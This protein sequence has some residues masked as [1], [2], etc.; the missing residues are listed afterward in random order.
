[1]KK[2]CVV[3]LTISILFCSIALFPFNISAAPDDGIININLYLSGNPNE[4]LL[5]RSINKSALTNWNGEDDYYLF[6]KVINYTYPTYVQTHITP[7]LC[8]PN[9]NSELW[10]IATYSQMYILSSAEVY[11]Y[12]F[13]HDA[14]IEN[15][16][17]IDNRQFYPWDTLTNQHGVVLNGFMINGYEDFNIALCY[18]DVDDPLDNS[19]GEF[20][21]NLKNY[22]TLDTY[23]STVIY[24]KDIT[25]AVG[26][27]EWTIKK[28]TFGYKVFN[29]GQ[30]DAV[31]TTGLYFEIKTATQTFYY[32]I[33]ELSEYLLSFTEIFIET[34]RQWISLEDEVF[35]LENY[36]I[37]L[38]PQSFY[39]FSIYVKQTYLDITDI[40][41]NVYNYNATV[42]YD[43]TIL[44]GTYLDYY[45]GFSFEKTTEGTITGNIF[46][47]MYCNSDLVSISWA[48]NLNSHDI[49]DFKGVN[50][51][52]GQS[53]I[54]VPY[55]G[56]EK[57]LTY[58]GKF[59]PT[60]D[61]NIFS[62]YLIQGAEIEE[63]KLENSV[64]YIK[65]S[66]NKLNHFSESMND[67][68]N[69]KSSYKAEG[70]YRVNNTVND[71]KNTM[72]SFNE[73]APQMNSIFRQVYDF[74]IVLTMLTLVL[75]VA[76][77]SYVLYGKKG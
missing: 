71:L 5:S 33:V 69:E 40:H 25:K 73:N 62:I 46:L 48:F 39:D 6:L 3:I 4:S 49:T 47:N 21:F 70:G 53:Y 38:N 29:F 51:K 41:V 74:P 27:S 24:A 77:I 26:T 50:F 12:Y 31:S 67:L 8:Y 34:D 1:M 35:N 36:N 54:D 32:Y 2:I 76:L 45:V 60:E 59:L 65:D 16:Y 42:L 15:V 68:E 11:T 61:N 10:N 52:I 43:S 44:R 7:I 64:N 57:D 55:D 56:Q 58:Y 75:S 17:D 63:I 19:I 28:I 72:Q 20:V 14:P 13:D 66:E 22:D 23:F 37:T 9:N 30:E 18:N